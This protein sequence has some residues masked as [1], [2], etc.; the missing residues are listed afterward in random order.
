V[1]ARIAAATGDDEDRENEGD[2]ILAADR[3]TPEAVNF[4]RHARGLICVSPVSADEST[5]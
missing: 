2:L 1:V 5:R 3:V 4:A